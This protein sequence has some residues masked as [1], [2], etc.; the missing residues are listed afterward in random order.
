MKKFIYSLLCCS[1]ALVSTMAYAKDGILI[2]LNDGTTMF[3]PS[4][5]VELIEF[6][7]EY[8]P[9]AAEKLNAAGI[10]VVK[11]L[12]ADSIPTLTEPA[13]V[14]ETSGKTKLP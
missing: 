5:K 10:N 8:M 12:P 9:D 6:T 13:I 7:E 11:T 4:E 2:H 1:A 14:P 3:F